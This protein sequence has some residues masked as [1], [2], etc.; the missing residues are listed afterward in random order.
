MLLYI[1][2]AL[3]ITKMFERGRH[4][5]KMASN[6]LRLGPWNVITYIKY[7]QIL[8]GIVALFG[9]FTFILSVYVCNETVFGLPLLLPSL[10]KI[11]IF[12]SY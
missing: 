5:K 8:K 10:S 3:N 4:Y 1:A 2:F 7:R 12:S 6:I 11:I 9:N